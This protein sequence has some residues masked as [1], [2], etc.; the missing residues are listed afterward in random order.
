MPIYRYRCAACGDELDAFQ[1]MSD[2]PLQR[3][4]RC[5]SNSLEKLI[6]PAVVR[7]PE[8]VSEARRG[9]GKGR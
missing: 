7:V 2:E 6:L 8:P 1:K 9:R 5:G 3:C 4:G